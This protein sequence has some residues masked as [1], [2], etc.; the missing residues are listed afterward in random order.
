MRVES[1]IK[2]WSETF[3]LAPFS[4]GVSSVELLARPRFLV[5]DNERREKSGAKRGT[6]GGAK[7]VPTSYFIIGHT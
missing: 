2:F 5:N 6:D 4:N 3:E 1:I 7:G